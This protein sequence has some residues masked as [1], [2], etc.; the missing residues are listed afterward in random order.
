MRLTDYA[1]LLLRV[2]QG[3][4]DVEMSEAHMRKVCLDL[5]KLNRFVR[6]HPGR[7]LACRVTLIGK[8]ILKTDKPL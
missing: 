7:E 1:G 6:S 3:E 4:E 5:H 2:Q 8:P